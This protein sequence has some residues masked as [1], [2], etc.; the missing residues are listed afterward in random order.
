MQV[1]TMNQDDVV[2][3]RERLSALADGELDGDETARLMEAPQAERD[4]LH[5]TWQAY[6]LIGD[7]LRGGEQTAVH[8]SSDF[9]SRLQTRLAQEAPLVPARPAVPVAEPVQVAAISRASAN[10][11]SFR[12]KMVA[13]CASFVAV[14]ALAW[15][16]VGGAGSMVQQPQMA[17]LPAPVVEASAA[18][19]VVEQEV[20]LPSGEA[21]VMLRDARL[22]ELLAAHKQAGSSSALQMPVPAGLLRSATFTAPER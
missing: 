11:A 6:H 4:G 5:Q 13:G 7:V 21:Q 22:D 8:A 17:A 14:A 3:L 16:V 10:D 20:R 15:T 9:L 19:Q 2:R 12:W 1:T 18:P